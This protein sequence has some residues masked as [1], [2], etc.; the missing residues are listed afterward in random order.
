MK[1]ISKLIVS[2]ASVLI[3]MLLMPMMLFAAEGTLTGLGTESNPY[4][5]KT[6]NDFK[7]IQDGIKG[8][9]SYKNKYMTQWLI[10]KSIKLASQ[11][12]GISSK[13][14]HKGC[15]NRRERPKRYLP[16]FS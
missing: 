2:I 10:G 3:G 4:I 6:E 13:C 16:N 8:G 7:S 14:I 1:N 11:C 15:L 9:K 5:I 12:K